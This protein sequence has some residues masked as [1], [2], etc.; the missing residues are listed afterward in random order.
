M[1]AQGISSQ[2]QTHLFTNILSFAS[3]W[4]PFLTNQ[5]HS[6]FFLFLFSNWSPFLINQISSLFLY[7]HDWIAL[8]FL[9]IPPDK[10][11]IKS[12]RNKHALK[13]ILMFFLVAGKTCR[14]V[15][16]TL[17][18]AA[19]V[20]VFNF[21]ADLFFG[22]RQNN[23]YLMNLEVDWIF[24]SNSTFWIQVKLIMRSE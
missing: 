19:K 4:L 12:L 10:C 15:K 1:L 20:I 22:S 17:K 2:S 3:D 24:F 16:T 9:T 13:A 11:Q 14:V 5:R 23:S 21:R 8:F 18:S 6:R 7:K